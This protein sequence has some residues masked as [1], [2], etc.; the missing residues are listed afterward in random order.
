MKKINSILLKSWI[1]SIPLVIIVIYLIPDIFSK[2]EIKPIAQR[3]LKNIGANQIVYLHDLDNDGISEEIYSYL[4]ED[5]HT[6]MVCKAG[7]TIDQWNFDGG[8]IY[9]ERLAFADINNDGKDEIFLFTR[10]GDF[11]NLH[12]LDPLNHR[13]SKVR[14]NKKICELNN[15][16]DTPNPQILF[17]KVDDIDADGFNDLSFVINSGFAIFPRNIFVYNHR[18]NTITKSKDYGSYINEGYDIS[19]IDGNNF[20]EFVGSTRAAGNVH[21]SLDYEFHDYSAWLMVYNHDLT[22]RF[23][24]IERKGFDSKIL[25]KPIIR[26]GKQLIACFYD[27]RGEYRNFPQLWL[28]DHM[29]DSIEG[30]RFPESDKISRSFLADYKQ[31]RLM[32]YNEF[33]MIKVFNYNLELIDSI[34][35]GKTIGYLLFHE[36]MDNDGSKEYIFSSFNDSIVITQNDFSDPISYKA[37]GFSYGKL[38]IAKNGNNPPSLFFYNDKNYMK[39]SYEKNPYSLFEYVIYLGIFL[40]IW[41]FIEAIRKMQRIQTEK[42]ERIRRK[43]VDLQLKNFGNQL[44]P[45]FTFN[46]FNTMA[47]EIK[48][49]GPKIYEIF[50]QFTKLVRNVLESS[51]K[52]T[53][54]IEEEID[55]LKSYLSL[56]QERFSD[57]FNYNINIDEN[58]NQQSQI[59]KM[60]LQTYVENA[61]KHGIRLKEGPGTIL[62]EIKKRNNELFFEIKDDGIGRKKAKELSTGTTGFG[63]QI[64]ENYYNLFNEYNSSKIK[65]EITDLYDHNDNPTGTIVKVI[66]PL[67]FSFKISKYERR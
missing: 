33:G 54:T 18:I 24:P 4:S 20:K 63:L 3:K 44:D 8:I 10:T 52:I 36:D 37:E 35:L 50:M 57:K 5:E 30:I 16:Y 53:R 61:I 22:L 47:Y 23:P 65:H 40:A 55:Y 48:R 62:I 51:D 25:A 15:N 39:C 58:V 49:N 27:H 38:Q 31:K 1:W 6:I 28:V 13:K 26:D 42:N 14:E 12:C 60:L 29:G 2:Y 17:L 7:G 32:V 34:S 56:E 46:V 45:H 67:K 11:V 19:D 64:M 66:I 59:P 9:G 21:D 43:I 41:L